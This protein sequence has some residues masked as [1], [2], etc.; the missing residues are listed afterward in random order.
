MLIP[1]ARTF[2]FVSEPYER[3]SDLANGS[4]LIY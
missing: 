1:V 2:L 4:W 3:S